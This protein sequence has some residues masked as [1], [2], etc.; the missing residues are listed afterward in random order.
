MGGQ[1]DLRTDDNPHREPRG[2]QANA[3][4]NRPSRQRP[5][6]CEPS[7]TRYRPGVVG[8]AMD[9]AVSPWNDILSVALIVLVPLVVVGG[10]IA[11]T[12]VGRRRRTWRWAVEASQSLLSTS[13]SSTWCSLLL[14]SSADNRNKVHPGD[15]LP[16]LLRS[17][18]GSERRRSTPRSDSPLTPSRVALSVVHLLELMCPEGTRSSEHYG[19]A[20]HAWAALLHALTCRARRDTSARAAS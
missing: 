2:A 7:P 4:H 3:T 17:L 8:S 15:L 19:R 11:A 16:S 13:S 1:S 20:F 10:T 6:S 14:F 18:D 12:V 5:S 9:W